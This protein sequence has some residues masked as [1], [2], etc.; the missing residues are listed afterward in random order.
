[1]ALFY[2]LWSGRHG[3]AGPF[4]ISEILKRDPSARNNKAS[5]LWGPL[6]VPHHWG[7]SVFGHY[8]CDDDAVLRKHAQMLGDAGVD[9]IIFDVTNQLTY[10]ESWK[11]LGR[12]FSEERAKG[13]HTPRIAFLCPFGD[14]GNVVRELYTELYRPGLF[15]DLWFPWDGKPLILADPARLEKWVTLGKTTEPV[16]LKKGEKLRQAVRIAAG[17]MRLAACL[18]TWQK[19][20]SGATLTLKRGAEVVLSK[21][22]E[23]LSDNGWPALELGATLPGDYVL[24][25]S[26]PVGTV[27]WWTDGG[28]R[29][30]RMSRSEGI[31]AEALK[32][33]TFRKPQPDYFQGPTGP[34]QWSWLEVFPQHEFKDE[35]GRVEQMTVG[36][37]QNALDGRLSALSNPRSHG[38]SFHEGKEPGEEGWTH[39]GLNF[40]EQWKRA[41]EVDPRCLFLTGWNEWIASRFDES[42]PFYGSGP[43]TFVDQFNQ[44]F[45]RDIE[46]MKGGHGDAYFY[47][48]L[49]GIRRHKG[50][51]ALPP[52]TSRPVVI[53][54]RF[55]DWREVAPEF[56]DTIGD[57]MKRD[58]RGWGKGTRFVETS[59]R[60]D[61]VA[62]KVSVDG[63]KVRFYVRTADDLGDARQERWMWLFVDTDDNPRDGWLGFDFLIGRNTKEGK[64][65]LEKAEGQR[66]A[67]SGVGD[68]TFARNGNEME[69]EVPRAAL[70]IGPGPF[71][72]RFKWA[73]NIEGN[74][75]WSD[76]VLHGDSAP[77][78]RFTYQ[79]VLE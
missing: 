38:R 69:I 16:A 72:L 12:V 44:E 35:K 77:N 14:P 40:A 34:N 19:T 42:A 9:V 52:V 31:E 79:A 25:L 2:F 26:E 20:D 78:D 54:G 21:R 39:S 33:F 45:S 46:P 73:D 41:R 74:G 29:M 76:F 36:V 8:V 65:S 11:A 71:T 28:Q 27:G 70:G 57:P 37:A 59:G 15:R 55:E 24:E 58:Y 13:N 56:R 3:E 32:F 47:Q 18:P 5:P 6:T 68:V 66:F 43:V 49:D 17:D 64:R 62:A 23:K 7:E 4:D 30:V 63:D 48:M 1:M 60:H 75:D 67:W 53:D 22:F 10:P 61:I 50:T 51:R